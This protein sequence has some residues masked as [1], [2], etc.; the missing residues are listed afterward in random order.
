ME[1][2]GLD[3]NG[4]EVA[5]IS[6]SEL[7]K[8]FEEVRGK[9]IDSF[10]ERLKEELKNWIDVNRNSFVFSKD[11]DDITRAN[12]YDNVIYLVDELVKET[13]GVRGVW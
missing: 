12:A 11:Y 2:I 6:V 1:I 9:T 10:S 7:N 13:K 5:M 4:D 3:S 8:L